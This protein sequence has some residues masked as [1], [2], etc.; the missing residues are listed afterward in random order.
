MLNACLVIFNF[1][2][3]FNCALG[4]LICVLKDFVCV[5]EHSVKLCNF[6]LVVIFKFKNIFVD[7]LEISLVCLYLVGSTSIVLVHAFKKF[8]LVLHSGFFL[9]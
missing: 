8:L 2:Y 4:D 6:L 1:L 5:L 7:L 3:D 9:L